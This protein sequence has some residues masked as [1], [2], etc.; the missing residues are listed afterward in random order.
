MKS[1]IHESCKICAAVGIIVLLFFLQTSM[2]TKGKSN[3]VIY[4]VPQSAKITKVAYYMDEYKG[5]QRLHMKVSLK[6]T[7]QSLTRYRVNL[8]L[9][10]GVAGGGLYPRKADGIKP[11]KVHTRVF[12]MYFN[13]MPKQFKIIITELQMH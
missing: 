12:P 4:E 8:Y 13:D 10:D 3:A 5:K 1:F 7:S 2:A 11:G 6:N 9:A